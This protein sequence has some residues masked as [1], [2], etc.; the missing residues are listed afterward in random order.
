M[1]KINTISTNHTFV[2]SINSTLY[3]NVEHKG[4]VVTCLF[5][6]SQIHT[7]ILV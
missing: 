6:H 3:I 4:T 1:D 5:T 2:K 7:Q